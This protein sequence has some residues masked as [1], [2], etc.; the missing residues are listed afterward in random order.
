MKSG[1]LGIDFAQFPWSLLWNPHLKRVWDV[2]YELFFR[3]AGWIWPVMFSLGAIGFTPWQQIIHENPLLWRSFGSDDSIMAY[4]HQ[5]FL[6]TKWADF[7]NHHTLNLML[8]AGLCFGLAGWFARQ[9]HT[10]IWRWG[11]LASYGAVLTWC[12]HE[13]LWWLT[14]WAVWKPNFIVFSGL[15]EIITFS[16]LLFT[17]ALGLYAPKRYV[18]WML[19]FQLV[20][21]ATGFQITESYHGPTPIYG[22][23]SAN[24]WEVASWAWACAGFYLL[25]R[26]PMLAWFE[27]V[28]YISLHGQQSATSS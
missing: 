22:T 10:T 28:K 21:V 27:K 24:A 3:N 14:Y 6:G 13:G 9:Q 20:W 16:L 25:E 2:S 7:S 15:G 26:K 12:V 19:A 17:L 23:I 5:G 4:M 11:L 1:K 8:E 18:L